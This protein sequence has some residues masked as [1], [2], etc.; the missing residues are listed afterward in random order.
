[1]TVEHMPYAALLLH[2]KIDEVYGAGAE[3]RVGV[4]K[5]RLKPFRKTLVMV[6]LPC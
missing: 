3:T 2:I 5:K 1:M 6:A 4:N